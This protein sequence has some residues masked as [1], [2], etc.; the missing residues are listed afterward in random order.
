MPKRPRKIGSMWMAWN[1][2]YIHGPRFKDPTKLNRIFIRG[3]NPNFPRYKL[4][5]TDSGKTVIQ[6]VYRKVRPEEKQYL[7]KLIE[8]DGDQYIFPKLRFKPFITINGKR[9]AF[10]AF[11]LD[12]KSLKKFK[13]QLA[14]RYQVRV[15]QRKANGIKIYTIYRGAKK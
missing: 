8:W 14:K 15:R 13:D 11:V 10:Y 12:K 3:L 9:W 5:V 2:K 1:M 6:S 4:G 7:K